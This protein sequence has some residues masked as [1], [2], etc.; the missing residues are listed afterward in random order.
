MAGVLFACTGPGS[1]QHLFFQ[2]YVE[3]DNLGALN[4]YSRQPDSFDD[5]SEHVGLLFASHAAIAFAG[6]EKVR[7]LTIA[8]SRRDRVGQAKG[9]LM[10]RFKISADQAFALLV[11]VSLDNN[12]KLYDLVE[13]LTRTG[14]L[15]QPR[16]PAH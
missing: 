4:L 13:D 7:H 12:L 14:H 1:G 11:R 2:L 8:V 9:N 16:P 5:D 15:E 3:H 10:E 6:A